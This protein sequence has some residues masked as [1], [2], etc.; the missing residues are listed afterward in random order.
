MKRRERGEGSVYQRADG[1]WCSSIGLGYDAGRYQ[2]K[3]FY[4]KTRKEV[5]E[6]LKAARV[7]RDQGMTVRTERQT[8]A[9]Y[10]TT[11]LATVK[12]GL[13]PG[14]YARYE[15]IVRLH[16]IPAIGQHRLTKLTA[17]HVAALLA[18]KAETGTLSPT[19]ISYIRLVLS[20]ALKQAMTW[21][22]IAWNVASVVPGPKATPREVPTLTMD[23]I[24]RFLAATHG[25]RLAALFVLALLAGLRH[26][27]LLGLRWDDVDLDA[28]TIRIQRALVRV[29]STNAL[30]APK[31]AMSR[32]TVGLPLVA[33]LAL[34][35]RAAH[36][37][38]ERRAAGASWT[39]Q[40][41]VFTNAT[42]APISQRTVL[43]HLQR[44]V[45]RARLPRMRLHDLRHGYAS[46]LLAQ[47]VHPKVVQEALGHSTIGITM[48]LYSHVLPTARREIVSRLDALLTVDETVN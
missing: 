15:Q 36:Q 30:R 8:V 9:Q 46:L 3:V 26:G 18:A 7:Q 44:I 17:E 13:A 39:E 2:R 32:R 12:P 16:L 19:S 27:E 21:R 40:G 5:A 20:I 48:D 29:G 4:G 45:E 22:L 34:R 31:T 10:L 43:E 33:V 42:G 14:S 23:D 47:N 25:E 38:E 35:E 41:F 6:K 37:T 11:W 28:S 24:A 1:R